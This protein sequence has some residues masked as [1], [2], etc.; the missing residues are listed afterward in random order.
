M[1]DRIVTLS[2]GLPNAQGG[3][4]V[5]V[6]Y[7]GKEINAKLVFYGP[8]LCGKTTNLEYIYGSIPSNSRGKMVSMKTKTERTLFFDFLPIELGEL[9]GFK[10]RFLLYTVPGQVYYNATRKLVLKGVDAIVFVA[11]SGRGKMEENLESFEN[12]RENLSE[13]GLS[14]DEIPYVIQYNKRDLPDVYSVE[15]LDA[16]LNKQGVPSF[17]AVATKGDG[18]FD[19][20]KVVSKLLLAKLSKEIGA[21][22]KAATLPGAPPAAQAP[23][24]QKPPVLPEATQPPPAIR[25]ETIPPGPPPAP[26]PVG[27][28][29]S[30]AD[31]GDPQKSRGLWRWF[32]QDGQPGANPASE[33][34][35]EPAAVTPAEE[36]PLPVAESV[37]VVPPT[38]APPVIPVAE[39]AEESIPGLTNGYPEVE[40]PPQPVAPVAQMP[41]ISS[42]ADLQVATGD[43]R[44][45]NNEIT[46]PIRIPAQLISQQLVIRLEVHVAG[47]KENVTKDREAA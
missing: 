30:R 45:K 9:A 31:D 42:T 11:D 21:P 32:K 25:D 46:I 5:L 6:S 43:V 7:T 2:P 33:P 3:I 44:V 20:F 15:E 8:G 16:E 23:P 38:A 10:T 29:P 14:L 39:K 17:E 41:D 37:E 22:V 26:Q 35:P 40:P 24:A 13:H 27:E 18:V 47:E 36:T 19:T 28:E 1:R 34:A 12:L 4:M